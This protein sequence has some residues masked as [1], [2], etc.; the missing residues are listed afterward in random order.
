MTLS[1]FLGDC[2]KYPLLSKKAERELI[3]KIVVGDKNAR[4][5]L[6]N[7][8]LKLCYS[9]AV[10]Y[11]GRGVSLD[12]LFQQGTL[13]LIHSM[14]VVD[15]N[16]EGK[17][18]TYATWWI[19]D[20]ISKLVARQG[21]TGKFNRVIIRKMLTWKRI[22]SELHLNPTSESDIM[23]HLQVTSKAAKLIV[24]AINVY[25]ISEFDAETFG[26]FEENAEVGIDLEERL[27]KLNTE[28]QMLI[29]LK[30]GLHSYPEMSLREIGEH[31]GE[32]RQTVLDHL[33]I[34]LDKLR[35]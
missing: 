6:I 17:F 22:A 2:N 4:D 16:Y 32:S 13:G 9:I 3:S 1:A 31:F 23:S 33:N 30:F 10:T 18:S 28:E 7:S 26:A 5:F 19:K 27:G 35:Y 15:H 25:E 29:N 14:E 8:N 20:S 21:K 24:N 34:A 11:L 12:D